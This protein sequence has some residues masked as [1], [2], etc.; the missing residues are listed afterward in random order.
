[1]RGL[2]QRQ[3]INSLMKLWLI[4]WLLGCSLAWGQA[5]SP[6]GIWKYYEEGQIRSVIETWIDKSGKLNGKIVELFFRQGEEPVRI[7]RRC[8]GGRA[9]KKIKGLHFLWGLKPKSDTY[10]VR[11]EVLE[12]ITGWVF[13]CNAALSEQGDRLT[14]RSY[15]LFPMLGKS[16]E[17]Q[18][19]K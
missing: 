19:V 1:M 4:S 14:I 7:C 2:E 15:W 9:G 13:S 3:K 12:P 5:K 6:V 16:M 10:W 17:W 18:R 8:L 11:G